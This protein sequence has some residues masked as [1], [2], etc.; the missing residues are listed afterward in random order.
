MIDVIIIVVVVTK[1]LPKETNNNNHNQH[2]L[3]IGFCNQGILGIYG[4]YLSTLFV[5]NPWIP[6]IELRKQRQ[7]NKKTKTNKITMTT[8]TKI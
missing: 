5:T 8:M 2:M 6:P 3:Y 1:I 7:T 4:S